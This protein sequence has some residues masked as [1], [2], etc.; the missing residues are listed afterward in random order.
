MYVIMENNAVKTTIG[1]DKGWLL[2]RQFNSIHIISER[3][4]QQNPSPFK[5]AILDR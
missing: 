2:S 5:L 4:L 3:Y 1:T